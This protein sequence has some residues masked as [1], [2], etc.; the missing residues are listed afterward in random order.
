[1]SAQPESPR[2][3]RAVQEIYADSQAALAALAE[4][5]R[6]L[7]GLVAAEAALA[8]AALLQGGV[9]ALAGLVLLWISLQLLLALLVLGLHAAGLGWGVALGLALLL[10]LA[11]VAGCVGY[12]RR[13]LRQT[14]FEASRRQW[15]A[16]WREVA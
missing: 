9:A 15:R 6:S 2:L 12:G 8:G 7:R 10:S 4:T 16:L 14:R 5:T 11:A 13:C 3:D 1:M